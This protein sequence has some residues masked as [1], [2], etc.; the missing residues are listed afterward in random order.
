MVMPERQAVTASAV[1]VMLIAAGSAGHGSRPAGVA[2]DRASQPPMR[3]GNGRR[4]RLPPSSPRQAHE[5]LNDRADGATH[6]ETDRT[7][8]SFS[9]GDFFEV[10][11]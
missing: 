6:P 7:I 2:G 11:P 3:L 10:S 9:W 5:H 4:P 8:G 1:A